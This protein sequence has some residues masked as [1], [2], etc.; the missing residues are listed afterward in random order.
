MGAAAVADLVPKS[1]LAKG[2]SGL[3]SRMGIAL[4]GSP[5]LASQLNARQSYKMAM[6]FAVLTLI[7]D[8]VGSESMP[9]ASLSL[10]N[11]LIHG[12]DP[13]GRNPST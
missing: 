10:S 7:N 1:Q 5:L 6:F 2:F 4:I 8:Q 12:A 13:P 11:T 3:W 9:W